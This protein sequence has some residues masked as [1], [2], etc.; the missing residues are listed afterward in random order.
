MARYDGTLAGVE[1]TT[2]RATIRRGEPISIARLIGS[3]NEGKAAKI[4]EA[5]A[6]VSANA[7]IS[8]HNSRL[9]FRDSCD[10]HGLDLLI[11][12]MRQKKGHPHM[13]LLPECL[14]LMPGTVLKR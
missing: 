1:K 13:A 10:G 2:V 6:T 5:S 12:T 3:G 4:I 9:S 14:E 7:R 8:R 11:N